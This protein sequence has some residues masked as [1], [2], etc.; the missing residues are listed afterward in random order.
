[1]EGWVSIYRKLLEN[2]IVCKDSDYLAVWIYLLLNATHVEKDAFFNRKRITLQPGQLITGRK[3]IAHNFKG[4]SES[5]VQRILKDFEIE[6][7]IAQQTTN[8]NRLVSILKWNEYQK[9]AQQNEQPVNNQCTTNEQPVNTNNNEIMKQCNNEIKI[10]KKESKKSFDEMIEAYTDN[11]EL[12]VELKNHLQTRKAKKASMTNRAIE[13]SL[14][15][16]DKLANNDYDKIR[17]VQQSIERGWIG[18]F[19]IKEHAKKE[20]SNLFFDLLREEGKF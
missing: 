16:L 8:H 10:N 1:M 13:L 18:F 17:I 7:Q 12:Q 19:E 15:S 6:Q 14:K 11:Y 4:L 20:N 2:P 5:K 3:S 9:S